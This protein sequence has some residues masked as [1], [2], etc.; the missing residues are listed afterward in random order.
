MTITLKRDDILKVQDIKVEKV[1]VPEWGG[2]VYIKGMNGMERDAFEASVVQMRGKGTNVDMSNI[3]AKLAAQTICDE[4]GER[5]FTDADI[6][7]LGKKSASAL[8]R[9]FEVA[10]KLSGIGDD[11]IQELTEGLKVNPLEDSPTA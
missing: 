4:N 8:Q 11:A 9:V 7:A 10:Q 1:H 6:K 2:D 3:R 5:L